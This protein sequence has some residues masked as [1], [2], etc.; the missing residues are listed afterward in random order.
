[1]SLGLCISLERVCEKMTER[2]QKD[3][4]CAMM[5]PKDGRAVC[6]CGKTLLFFDEET[7]IDALP[8]KCKKCGT[9]WR[10]DLDENILRLSL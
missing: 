1:M 8:V 5:K 4:E 7:K 9:L 10:V 2:L 6:P 3:R